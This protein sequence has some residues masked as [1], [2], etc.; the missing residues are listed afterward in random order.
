MRNIR[1]LFHFF[2]WVGLSLEAVAQY[3]H[4][5][6]DPLAG[7]SRHERAE[8]RS[9]AASFYSAPKPS[10]ARAV[11]SMV[12]LYYR[13]HKICY[14]TIVM[15]V[16]SPKP[17]ILTKWS[18]IKHIRGEIVIVTSHG[19]ALSA[20]LA[21]IYP[22]HDLAMLSSKNS[23]NQLKPIAMKDQVQPRLGSFILLASPDGEVES[24]GV[25]SVEARSLR[26][27]DKAYLGVMMDFEKG[28]K[29]VPLKKIMPGSAAAKAG[30]REGDII[31][32]VD[33]EDLSGALE[34]RT[35][36]QRLEPGSNITVTYQRGQQRKKAN[37]K[38][39][40]LSENSTI[41]RVP[42]E[43]MNIMERMG[44][45]PSHVRSNFPRVIQSDMP[46]HPR[47]TGAPVTD[48]DGNFAGIAI[49]RGSRIKTYIIPSDTIQKLLSTQPHTPQSIYAK[50]HIENK[51]NTQ[52]MDETL[53]DQVR[54]LLGK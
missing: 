13:G 17:V 32:A 27:G 8:L 10:V 33:H 30:L 52:P 31:L 18:E 43:R 47:D 36:L 38:L 6:P 45:T 49:A 50:R 3:E 24:V 29:G 41:R 44:T 14:G 25:V 15:S 39:G 42:Q 4:R 28:E 48:L 53:I 12:T 22:D 20:S 54:R 11:E 40:S 5:M 9:Q 51:T 2:V 34:M 7:L 26:D 37:V 23:A 35:L 46:I 16:A 19:K 21:G 1:S